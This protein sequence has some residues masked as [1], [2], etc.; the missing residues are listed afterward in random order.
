MKKIILDN[1]RI[2]LREV[3][4]DVGISFAKF[5]AIF[6]NFLGMKR[7]PVKIFPILIN[8]GQNQRRMGIAQEISDLLKKIITFEETWVYGYDI[9]TKIQSS[10]CNRSE[11][12]R[13]KKH[14]KFDQMWRFCLMVFFDCNGVVH[15]EFLPQGIL[16]WSYEPTAQSNSLET[17]NIVEKQIKFNNAPAHTSILLSEFLNRNITVIMPQLP[18]SPGLYPADFMLFPNWRYRWKKCHLLRLRG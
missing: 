3:A 4:D 1:L 2:S 14:V 11:E 16:S 18:Y 7:A 13:S 10:H 6:T 17:D 12:P 15:H 5:Q 8:F 9:K